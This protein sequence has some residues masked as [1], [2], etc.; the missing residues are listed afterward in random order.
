MWI[1]HSQTVCFFALQFSDQAGSDVFLPNTDAYNTQLQQLR[2]DGTYRLKCDLPNPENTWSLQVR[3]VVS[4][5]VTQSSRL[6]PET[7]TAWQ[8]IDAA[9]AA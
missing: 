9:F 3:P 1:E 5:T 8:W 4:C 7:A 6:G 2:Q